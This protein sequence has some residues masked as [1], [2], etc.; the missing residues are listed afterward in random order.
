MRSCQDTECEV[1]APTATTDRLWATISTCPMEQFEVLPPTTTSD[2]ACAPAYSV[3]LIF[4]AKFNALAGTQSRREAFEAA[5]G[6][7]IATIPSLNEDITA[8]LFNRSVSC[9]MTVMAFTASPC[10]ADA[11]LEPPLLPPLPTTNDSNELRASNAVGSWTITALLEETLAAAVVVVV[12]VHAMATA[13]TADEVVVVNVVVLAFLTS[14]SNSKEVA[15]VLLTS[16]RQCSVAVCHAVLDDASLLLSLRRLFVNTA[17]KQPS[18]RGSATTTT[19]AQ[20]S[21]SHHCVSGV[22]QGTEDPQRRSV[23]DAIVAAA[24]LE[25]LAP[26]LQASPSSVSCTWLPSLSAGGAVICTVSRGWPA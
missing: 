16:H 19:R 21:T 17:A 11:F 18:A 4:D 8:C 7:I 2:R 14:S 25:R 9:D 1:S 23:D 22:L 20:S 6:S 12:V 15:I 3:S 10:E 26:V 24:A 5:L 13:A